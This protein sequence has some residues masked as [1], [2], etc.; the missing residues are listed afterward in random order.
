MVFTSKADYKNVRWGQSDFFF[1]LTCHTKL[2]LYKHNNIQFRHSYFGCLL[3]RALDMFGNLSKTSILTWCIQMHQIKNLYKFGL[4]W[5]SNLQENN[6]EK[7]LVA[8]LCVFRCIIKG[9]S[10]SLLLF[11]WEITSFSKTLL[12]QREPFLPMFY[13]TN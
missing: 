1:F 11:E 8:L 10:W 3:L 9:F 7:T 5:S 2:W 13:T 4:S 12:L 6:E